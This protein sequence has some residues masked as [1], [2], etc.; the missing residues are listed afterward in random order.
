MTKLIKVNYDPAADCPYW[1]RTME[2][3]F[4]GDQ[5]LIEFMQ[6]ALGYSL[7]GSV[8]E[9][10]LFICWGESGNNGKSTIMEAVSRLLGTGYAQMSDMKVITSAETDNRVASSLA[11]LHGSRLVNM[12]EAEEHQRLSEALVKQMTGGDAIE[13]CKKYHEP[14][15]YNPVFK[16]WIRT[17]E[18]PVIRGSGDAIWRRI[19]LIPFTKPI[20]AELR[21]S[22]DEVDDAINRE[23]E[24]IL[25]WMVQGFQKWK[26]DGLKEPDE[27]LS[28]VSDYRNE[29]D[30]ISQFFDECAVVGG[31]ETC[32][33]SELYQAFQ[34]WLKD[35]GYRIFMSADSFGRRV[36][37]KI[38]QQSREKVNGK[39][40]W[41]GLSVTDAALFNLGG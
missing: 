37:K 4:D 25:A 17:N 31:S 6:R 3:A 39:Y 1:K 40:I 21:R 15:N 8:S 11:K 14:F 7:S 24:G 35:N 12:N 23:F 34:G 27:V 18:K 5:H 13:A 33:R 26:T 30:I 41:R 32:L 19:K 20:P 16:L 36:S 38:P 10:C 28:A 22:R 2:L 9:Q 29:M